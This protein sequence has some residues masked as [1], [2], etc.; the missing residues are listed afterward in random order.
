[1]TSMSAPA[2]VLTD[3]RLA[4]VAVIESLH[5][6]EGA[7]AIARARVRG[8]DVVV[9]LHTFRV[10]DRVL[11]FEVDSH[12]DTSQDRFSF[13]AL[14]GQSTNE[15]GYTGHVLKT[16]RLRGQY[17]Q[18][19][20]LP[21]SDFPETDTFEVGD[22][23]TAVLGIVKWDPKLPDELEGS[24]RGFLPSWFAPSAEVRVQNDGSIFADPTITDWIA[25]LPP[26]NGMCVISTPVTWLNSAAPRWGADPLPEVE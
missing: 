14:R 11:Y 26:R 24:A 16:V 19:L 25:R 15:T 9:R 17:S 10:G 22:D 6:I 12:L 20:I 7:D 21:A 5:P 18:G 4:T 8:W 23:V 2:A 3:R 13:L 1:M